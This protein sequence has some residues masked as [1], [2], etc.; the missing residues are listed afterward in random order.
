MK[1]YQL[2]W[3]DD[4]RYSGKPDPSKWSYDVGAR[5]WGNGETQY[6]TEGLNVEVKDSCLTLVG[7]IEPFED[8]LP[9]GRWT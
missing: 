7:K 1:K 5:K 8:A 2:R 6:Y 4:F 9:K 3:E